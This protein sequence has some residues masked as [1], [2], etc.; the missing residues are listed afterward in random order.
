MA[1]TIYRLV[2][3]LLALFLA[4]SAF[5]QLS[6]PPSPGGG[7][8]SANC[9]FS[10]TTTTGALNA[11]GAVSGTAGT[12][13]TVNTTGA[14]GY[15]L[16]GTTILNVLGTNS[17]DTIGG[18]NAGGADPGGLLN[19]V[20]GD[21]AGGNMTQYTGEVALFGNL[22]GAFIGFGCGTATVPYNTGFGEHTLGYITCEGAD[23][24]IGNDSQRDNNGTGNTTSGSNTTGGKSVL[25]SGGAYEDT[26]FGALA[27][28]SNSS[29]IQ[30]T[31]P[32]SATGSLTLTFTGN[33][34]GSPHTTSAIAI[35]SGETAASVAAAIQSTIAADST[36]QQYAN[37]VG[38]NLV[39]TSNITL[40]FPGTATTGLDIVVTDTLTGATG[41]ALTITGG[42]I[43]FMQMA[44]GYQAAPCYYCTTAHN[45][46]G[47]DQ[48]SLY[49]MTTGSNDYALGQD[50]G[51]NTT[52][53]SFNFYENGFSGYS[54]TT[55]SFNFAAGLNSLYSAI[56]SSDEIA[57]G[58]STMQYYNGAFSGGQANTVVG[59]TSAQGNSAGEAYQQVTIFGAANYTSISGTGVVAIQ[60]LGNNNLPHATTAYEVTAIGN[61]LGCT[62][63]ATGHNIL[64]MSTG[65]SCVDTPASG[66]VN[67]MNIANALEGTL[68]APTIASGF[69]TSPTVSGG[70]SSLA[71]EITVGSGP[72]TSGVVNFSTGAPTAYVCKVT[73]ITSN[74]TI[75]AEAVPTGA[76]QCTVTFYSRTTGL[77]VSPN[78]SDVLAVTTGAF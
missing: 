75:I 38:T 6:P 64:L 13:A 66:T 47:L 60:V 7:G 11:T 40:V 32:A 54:N 70:T 3:P 59:A 44:F 36:L 17:S 26:A 46:F 19:T 35:T 42:N 52:S 67:Y 55:G 74:S 9:T 34:V 27:L 37:A 20:Y 61:G 24:A 28:S 63:L 12:F 30:V 65:A 56:T 16:G 53:G 73:D 68:A 45:F 72:G 39:D 8:C 14:A 43:G 10:G 77:A 78:A 25:G 1:H 71:F 4:Q 51:Y 15:Q 57:V 33:F 5:A 22:S 21:S 58:R 29:T 69:G 18:R 62:N 49:H 41:V 31:G 50:A 48:F 76:S 23:T 2:V